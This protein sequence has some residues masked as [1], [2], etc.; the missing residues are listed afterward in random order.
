M[1]RLL[2]PSPKPRVL[3]LRPHRLKALSFV[4]DVVVTGTAALASGSFVLSSLQLLNTIA[5]LPTETTKD[6]AAGDDDDAFVWSVATVLSLIPVFNFMVCT[7]L[8][9]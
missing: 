2:A 4:N 7:Q 6:I 3:V 5:Q 8:Q 1:Y 9:L